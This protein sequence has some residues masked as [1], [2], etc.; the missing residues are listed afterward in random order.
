MK[1]LENVMAQRLINDA[2]RNREL[3]KI[4]S[5]QHN[6]IMKMIINIIIISI[7]S[8]AINISIDYYE[9]KFINEDVQQIQIQGAEINV[10]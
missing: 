5:D 10:R 3:N 9:S 8:F 7:I 6:K 2:I 4:K 1:S